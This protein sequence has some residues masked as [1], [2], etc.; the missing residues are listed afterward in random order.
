M[1]VC[2]I[3][4]NQEKYIGHCLQSI[5]EQK[6]KFRFEVIVGE[7]CSVDRTRDIVKEFECKYPTIVR[8]VFHDCNI[9]PKNN[10]L[11]VLS[12]ANG[13]YLA[14]CEGDDYW[15]DLFKLQKQV[16]FMEANPDYSMCYHA[17]DVVD[18]LGRKTGR[19][20]GPYKKKSK[21]CSVEFNVMAG[22]VHLSSIFTRSKF[23][24]QGIPPWYIDIKTGDHGDFA[25]VLFLSTSGKTYFMDELMSA[26]RTG[27]ADSL[28]TK[29]R[30][31]YSVENE[32]NYQKRRIETLE[33]ADRYYNYK[34]HDELERANFSSFVNILL[35]E[36]RKEELKKDKCKKF[37]N[38]QGLWRKYK[39][40]FLIKHH[41]IASILVKIKEILALIVM[42]VSRG[43]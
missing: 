42:R 12:A 41:N 17:V 30:S 37:L 9:G 32:I 23:I 1:S 27:V 6:A 16:E 29:M 19:Y 38:E 35:L 18:I 4:Y 26:H 34:F 28:M 25:F 33:S 22:N 7:D 5:V 13:E 24:E 11:N 15:T 14:F 8:P 3:T 39:L 20:Y 31:K 2:V 36:G 40:I 43:R 21:D 10:F